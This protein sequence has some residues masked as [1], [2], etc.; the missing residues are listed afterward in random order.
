MRPSVFWCTNSQFPKLKGAESQA[1]FVFYYLIFR[2]Q[3]RRKHWDGKLCLRALDNAR[4]TWWYFH[5]FWSEWKL[6]GNCK[7][8]Q[9]N[10]AKLL[11][12]CSSKTNYERFMLLIRRSLYCAHAR[13][14][15]SGWSLASKARLSFLTR[16]S[17]AQSKRAE[18][19]VNQHYMMMNL[20]SKKPQGKNNLR[21]IC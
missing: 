17:K 7:E 16:E 3:N 10:R 1:D 14:K 2:S 20:P 15:A 13:R 11:C 18:P 5:Y 6:F 8:A 9:E 19:E 4:A 12:C 21:M